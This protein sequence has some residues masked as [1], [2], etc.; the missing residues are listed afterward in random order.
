MLFLS[1]LSHKSQLQAIVSASPELMINTERITEKTRTMKTA[2]LF[3][4]SFCIKNL[5]IKLF[6]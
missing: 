6:L 5:T 3:Q 4:I 2:D 1:L